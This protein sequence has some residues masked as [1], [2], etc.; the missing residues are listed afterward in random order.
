[1]VMIKY[2]L[3]PI[4]HKGIFWLIQT[5]VQQAIIITQMVLPAFFFLPSFLSFF[6]LHYC[7]SDP[8]AECLTI[9]NLSD[10]TEPCCNTEIV[11]TGALKNSLSRPGLQRFE[12]LQ[13]WLPRG[14]GGARQSRCQSRYPSGTQDRHCPL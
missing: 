9:S 3:L 10:L 12:L 5:V 4:Q 13:M 2:S 7:Q 8:A 11:G 1:M 14:P 6:F